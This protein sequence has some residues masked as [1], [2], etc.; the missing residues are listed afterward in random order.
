[1]PIPAHGTQEEPGDFD[2]YSQ[3][4]VLT[5]TQRGVTVNYNRQYVVWQ[6]LNT[7]NSVTQCT[8]VTKPFTL[9]D[10]NLDV[11]LMPFSFSQFG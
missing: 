3:T 10:H 7:N 2:E 4:V 8:I 1:M 9:N 5:V 6:K 11:T